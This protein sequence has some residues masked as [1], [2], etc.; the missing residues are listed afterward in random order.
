MSQ[1]T[2]A[3]YAVLKQ[4]PKNLQQERTIGNC[5]SNKYRFQPKRIREVQA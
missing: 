5:D 3:L 2:A 4:N 1:S